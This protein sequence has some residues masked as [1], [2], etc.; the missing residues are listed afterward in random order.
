MTSTGVK[1]GRA[2]SCEIQV[3]DISAELFHC[4]VKLVDGKP[5]VQNMASD[6]GVDVNGARVGEAQLKPMDS[7]RVGHAKFVLLASGGRRRGLVI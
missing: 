7:I 1:I 5:V 4:I 3:A 6:T 2:N